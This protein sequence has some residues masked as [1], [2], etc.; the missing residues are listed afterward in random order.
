ME[1]KMITFQEQHCDK[2][3]H[4]YDV[5]VAQVSSHPV[6]EKIATFAMIQPYWRHYENHHL[7][8]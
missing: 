8:N 2:R 6:T 4:I 3:P 7:N 5:V 1:L